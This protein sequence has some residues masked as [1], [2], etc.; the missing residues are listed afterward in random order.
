M[1][2]SFL[3]SREKLCYSFARLVDRRPPTA[4]RTTLQ[5]GAQDS[6]EMLHIIYTHNRSICP[7]THFSCECVEQTACP[8]DAW[9][10]S[11]SK[12]ALRSNFTF[13]LGLT[14]SSRIT[15]CRIKSSFGAL[16][17]HPLNWIYSDNAALETTDDRK[18]LVQVNPTKSRCHQ[19]Q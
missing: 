18:C 15:Y 6:F 1:L 9:H 17:A 5:P 19:R 16:C 2:Q 8:L 10:W 13:T 3:Q 7:N 11:W 12:M 4:A 14:A